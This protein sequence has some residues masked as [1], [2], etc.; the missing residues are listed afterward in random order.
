LIHPADQVPKTALLDT[1]VPTLSALLGKHNARHPERA[2]RLRAVVHAGEVTYDQNGCFGEA[3][4]VAFRLLDADPVKKALG[5]TQAPL[6][7]VVSD[8]VHR[9]VVR[10]GYDGIDPNAFNRFPMP[11]AEG[12]VRA[13]WIQVVDESRMPSRPTGGS[14]TMM[15]DYRRQA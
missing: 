9:S 14:V 11:R 12:L 7:L 10:H 13:G 15:A 1:V 2:F 6:V 5:A 8:D 3:L 4:D